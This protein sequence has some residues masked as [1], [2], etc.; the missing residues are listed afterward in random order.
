MQITTIHRTLCLHANLCT[1]IV[2]SFS[3]T[4]VVPSNTHFSPSGAG[5][6]IHLAFISYQSS[7]CSCSTIPTLGTSDHVAWQNWE[8]KLM[9]IMDQCVPKTTL[10]AKLKNLPKRAYQIYLCHKLSL[11][12]CYKRTGASQH[13]LSHRNE[14]VKWT[15]KAKRKFFRGL[16]TPSSKNFWKAASF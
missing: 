11:Q 10:P 8:T 5:S 4:Q 16:N 3:L 7:M 12:L 6:L 13:F 9:S 2:N 1:N 15:R 14:V